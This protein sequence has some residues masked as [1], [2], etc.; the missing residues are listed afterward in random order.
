VSN[1]AEPPHLTASKAKETAAIE[2]ALFTRELNEKLL[3]VKDERESTQLEPQSSSSSLPP[4]AGPP[5]RPASPS[6]GDDMDD[7]MTYGGESPPP[8][9]GMDD[10]MC[11]GGGSPSPSRS[12]PASRASSLPVASPVGGGCALPDLA[13][14]YLGECHFCHKDVMRGKGDPINALLYP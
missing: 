14:P 4:L 7:S 2:A 5:S 11:Y 8:E 13:N 6:P 9:F 3:I 12:S 1:S 10:S